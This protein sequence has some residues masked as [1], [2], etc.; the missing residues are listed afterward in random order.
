MEFIKL[1]IIIRIL[2]TTGILALVQGFI[3]FMLLAALALY[4]VEPELGSYSNILWYL[5]AS[6]TTI[7][8]GDIVSTTLLGRTITVIVSLYGI[9]IV[10]FIPAVIIAYYNEFKSAKKDEISAEFLEKLEHLHELSREELADISRK[11]RKN[12]NKL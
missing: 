5:F 9:L 3:V 1:H 2:R 6:F 7:G 12:R 10:A 11:I 8:Y 4:F